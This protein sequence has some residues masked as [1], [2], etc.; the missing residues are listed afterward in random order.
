MTE[1]KY[2][3]QAIHQVD[4]LAKPPGSLGLL[5]KQAKKVLLAW[6][7]FHKDLRPKHLI[8]RPIMASFILASSHNSLILRICRAGTW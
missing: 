1:D 2:M 4:N 5:E 6:G 3:K 7:Q 8:L